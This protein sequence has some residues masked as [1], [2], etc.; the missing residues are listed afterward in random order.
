VGFNMYF[1]HVLYRHGR[2]DVWVERGILEQG[3]VEMSFS[4]AMLRT[5]RL[6]GVSLM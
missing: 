6:Y 4:S 5:V 3:T 1:G 2:E